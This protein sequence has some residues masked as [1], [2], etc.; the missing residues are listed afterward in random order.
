MCIRDRAYTVYDLDELHNEIRAK[1][2]KPH[3]E[4]IRRVQFE[5]PAAP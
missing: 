4:A 2:I 1:D 5:L 3:A